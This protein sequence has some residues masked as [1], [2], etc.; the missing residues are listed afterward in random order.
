[1]KA[2]GL[3]LQADGQLGAETRVGASYSF[4]QT[5]DD[6]TG[7]ELE[8]APKHLFK[9]NLTAPVIPD[10]ALLGVEVQY[11]SDRYNDAGRGYRNFWLVNATLFSHRWKDRWEA[12][13]S[14]YNLF[15]ASY[16]RTVIGD[17]ESLQDGRLLRLKM[18][19][20]F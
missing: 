11:V 1:M 12:S 7:E 15:E 10:I 18:T 8:F 5:K 4:T 9:A 14:A 2:T 6:A 20:R 17:L 16:D 3:E 19:T 13:L